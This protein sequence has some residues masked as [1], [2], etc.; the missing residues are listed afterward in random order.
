MRF[1]LRTLMIVLALG[2]PL[3]AWLWYELTAEE[4]ATPTLL[5]SGEDDLEEWH[6]RRTEPPTLTGP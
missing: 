3:G 2:P 4:Q 6:Y 1:R 5:F